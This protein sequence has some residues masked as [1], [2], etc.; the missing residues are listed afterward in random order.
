ML[1]RKNNTGAGVM[2]ELFPLNQ[3]CRDESWEPEQVPEPVNLHKRI[4]QTERDQP[5]DEARIADA[6][7][8]A[9]SD[10]A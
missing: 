9:E 4:L 6:I 3:N 1:S 10:V 7:T 2:N 8:R 5:A